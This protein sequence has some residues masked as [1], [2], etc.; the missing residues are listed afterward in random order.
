LRRALAQAA[1]DARRV[2]DAF[3]VKVPVAGK[4]KT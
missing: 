3:N 2:A 4:A 1:R